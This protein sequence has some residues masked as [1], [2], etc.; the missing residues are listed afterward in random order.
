MSRYPR[1]FKFKC[2]FSSYFFYCCRMFGH[3]RCCLKMLYSLYICT[4]FW[5][6]KVEQIL[7]L[8]NLEHFP[9]SI[10]Y[11][12][13]KP[14]RSSMFLSWNIWWAW[15]ISVLSVH[16]LY[17]YCKIWQVSLSFE[18]HGRQQRST[19]S[20][21]KFF[22]QDL[23]FFLSFFLFSLWIFNCKRSMYYAFLSSSRFQSARSPGVVHL[24]IDVFQ[25][26]NEAS[27]QF[28]I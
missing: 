15:E 22:S 26:L 8:E 3:I 16:L 5:K 27:T 21:C 9:I 2:K 4:S 10:K 11:S 13:I 20:F 12:H 1:K 19:S 17:L 28:L 18:T 6:N 7:H 23:R 25:S 14:F 24:I